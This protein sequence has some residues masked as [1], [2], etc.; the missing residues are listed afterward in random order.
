MIKEPKTCS[1]YQ[2]P[3]IHL[4]QFQQLQ[5][6]AEALAVCYRKSHDIPQTPLKLFLCLGACQ[7]L[8]Q[9]VVGFAGFGVWGLGFRV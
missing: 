7:R 3:Y 4:V 9:S 2:G 8:T 5:E 6:L 1:S